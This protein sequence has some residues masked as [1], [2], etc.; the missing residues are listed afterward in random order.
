MMAKPMWIWERLR[1]ENPDILARCFKAR[2]RLAD[3]KKIKRRTAR[4]SVA[5]LSAAAERDLS[6]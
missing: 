3:P 6:K 1:K 5:V 2:R 4:E